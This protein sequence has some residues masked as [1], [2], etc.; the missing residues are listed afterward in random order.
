MYDEDESWLDRNYTGAPDERLDMTD[1]IIPDGFTEGLF[2]MH[3]DAYLEDA[4]E[5]TW[6]GPDEADGW[7]AEDDDDFDLLSEDDDLCDCSYCDN[8]RL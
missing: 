3:E 6:D 2:A 4:Y 8:E 5:S 7:I 1:R